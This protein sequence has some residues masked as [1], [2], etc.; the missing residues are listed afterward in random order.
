[1]SQAVLNNRHL[2]DVARGKLI[3]FE[4][5]DD[6]TP[7]NLANATDGDYATSTGTGTKVMSG[8]GTVGSFILDLGEIKTV[9]V[10]ARMGIWTSAGN[11]SVNIDS[12]DAGDTYRTL[13][14]NGN[15]TSITT[16]QIKPMLP[17]LVNARFIRLRVSASAAATCN[18]NVKELVVLEV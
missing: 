8:A 3:T 11:I 13:A 10:S 14:A 2:I 17:A 16:E 5:F 6:A 18:A 4:G 9:L 7:Y 1:M 15:Y 12:S